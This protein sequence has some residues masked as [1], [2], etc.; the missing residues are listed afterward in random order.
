MSTIALR[1][2]VTRATLATA[3]LRGNTQ[4]NLDVVEIHAGSRVACDFTVGYAAADADDHLF[5]LPGF[6]QKNY[7]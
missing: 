3:A 4:F 2:H 5:S 7:K 1:H 6:E